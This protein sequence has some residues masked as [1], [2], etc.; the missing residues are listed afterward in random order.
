MNYMKLPPTSKRLKVSTSDFLV[1]LR[2]NLSGHL[3]LAGTLKAYGYLYVPAGCQRS[4]K[5]DDR[6]Q[7]PG[8][9]EVLGR[10]GLEVFVASAQPC[11][12]TLS[13]G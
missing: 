6:E 7:P 9:T 12:P 2:A 4:K 11:C 8:N 5:G 3:I 10:M 1:R 13:L